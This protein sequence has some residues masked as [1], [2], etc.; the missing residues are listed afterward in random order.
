MK[1]LVLTQKVDQQDDVLGFF[2]EWLVHLAQKFEQIE[3]ICLYQ[4][5]HN[6]PSN[7]YIHSLGKEKGH[8]RVRFVFNFFVYLWKLRNSYDAV[9]VHMNPEYLVMGGWVWK[10]LQRKIVLWYSHRNV[11]L[12]LRIA[13]FFADEIISSASTSFLLKT[14]KLHIFG[15]GID[16]NFFVPKSQSTIAPPLRL[17]SVGRITP[18]KRIEVAIDALAL[19]SSY[20]VEAELSLV[21][22]AGPQD[23]EYLKKLQGQVLELNLTKKVHFVGAVSYKN[24]V[25]YYQKNDFSL[26]MAPSGGLDKAVLESMACGLPTIAANTGFSNL[27]GKYVNKLLFAEGNSEDL[28]QKIKDLYSTSDITKIQSFVRDQVV[29]K[30][31]LQ[32]LIGRIAELYETSR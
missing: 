23:G 21:G 13:E 3:V 24:I 29:K 5:Q 17:I 22:A 7:V 18:I 10:L 1:L 8:G 12:K 9:F 26:N 30:A 25:P 16:T 19:L 28:A 11:D 27:F 15:H 2:Y 4:G 31:D 20:G 14:K 6:L 32:N